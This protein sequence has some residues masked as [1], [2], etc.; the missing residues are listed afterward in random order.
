MG[1]VRGQFKP[2]TQRPAASRAG[3]RTPNI[4]PISIHGMARS[5]DRSFER[6]LPDAAR[7]SRR[8]GKHR[9]YHG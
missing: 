5:I 9:D 1:A 7:I 4:E 8:S 3:V 2:A 6:L